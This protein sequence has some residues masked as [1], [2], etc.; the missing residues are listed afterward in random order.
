MK[1]VIATKNKGKLREF[2][3]ILGPLGFEVVSQADC[4]ITG[5]AEENG[6][7]VVVIV[8]PVKDNTQQVRYETGMPYSDKSWIAEEY[9]AKLEEKGIPVLDFKD[10]IE[11]SGLTY[12]EVFYVTDHHWTT[13]AVF[14]C[15]QDFVNKMNGWFDLDLDPDGLY[16][17]INKVKI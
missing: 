16:T 17:N 4:G 3:R 8:P 11:Q 13:E 2:S 6:T 10:T 9:M 5:Q 15:Y 1:I 14:V 7:K 12:D